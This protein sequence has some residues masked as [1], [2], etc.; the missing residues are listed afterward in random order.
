[1]K[2]EAVMSMAL[3]SALVLVAIAGAGV[4]VAHD[5]GYLPIDAL[6]DTEE[7]VGDI[8]VINITCQCNC[9]DWLSEV[10]EYF[11]F[12]KAVYGIWEVS[13]VDTNTQSTIDS[14]Y[15]DKMVA[16]GYELYKFEPQIENPGTVDI[17]GYPTNYVVY[18]KGITFV[19]VLTTEIGDK[20][21]VLYATGNLML[22]QDIL[23]TAV[24]L[25]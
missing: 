5:Q 23:N 8:E 4:Y 25:Q 22:L 3:A 14:M 24:L 18:Y 13:V 11:I 19:S 20:I 2:N 7:P 17:Y 21:C 9:K 16:Q 15:V 1:M 6:L 10:M 12:D